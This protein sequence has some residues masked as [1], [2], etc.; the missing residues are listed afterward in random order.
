MLRESPRRR[1]SVVRPPPLRYS[2]GTGD[3]SSGP[4][5]LGGETTASQPVLVSSQALRDAARRRER[6]QNEIEYFTRRAQDY[7]DRQ[8]ESDEAKKKP[9]WEL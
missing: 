5:G 6:A 4:W 7:I 1:G 2:G 8:K 3:T 9:D